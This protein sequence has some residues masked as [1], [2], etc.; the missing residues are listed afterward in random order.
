MV[1]VLI[2]CS[3]ESAPPTVEETLR[4]VPTVAVV[5]LAPQH[6]AE[7]VEAVGTIK[8][9]HPT[10]L[11]AKV[12]S[13][14]VAVHVNAGNHVRAGQIL[15]TLDDRESQAQIQRAKA[16]RSDIDYALAEIDHALIAAGAVIEATTAQQTLAK[17]TLTRYAALF[18]R[19]SVAPQ[20]YDGV[21]AQQK[22]ATAAL[23]QAAANK[24]ALLAKRQQVL[25]KVAQATAGVTQA[26]VALS[27]AT[28]I[29]PQA[30]V[31]TARFVEVGTMATPGSP[32][33]ALDS[34]EYLLEAA[35]RESDAEKVHLGQSATVTIDALQ[36][37]LTGRVR[38]LLPANT[39]LSRTLT[40]KISLP[41]TPGLRSGLY[42]KSQLLVGQRTGLLAPTTA[43]RERGQMQSLFIV[44]A[45]SC[46]RMRLVTTGRILDGGVE[47]LSGVEAGE[48]V[49]TRNADALEDG[50]AVTEEGAQ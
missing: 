7:T 17:T 8:S 12:T 46:A 14:V 6:I 50:M 36:Q 11:A 26:Q 20:E 5:T 31:V 27:Y 44:D 2:G 3:H 32:L 41:P 42:G 15:V 24:A 47:L 19:G 43:L 21:A 22:T 48:R 18:E 16:E 10:V 34:E 45:Q 30:G 13:A 1:S 40:I 35:L 37:T 33:L 23:E 4:P 25:A 28:I 49:V 38:E 39:P 9:A 29:A